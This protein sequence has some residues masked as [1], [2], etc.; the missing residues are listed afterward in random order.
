MLAATADA[1][2]AA[3]VLLQAGAALEA[4]NN[5][6]RCADDPDKCFAGMALHEDAWNVFVCFAECAGKGQQSAWNPAPV[7]PAE[8]AFLLM[9]SGVRRTCLAGRCLYCGCAA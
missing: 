9:P 7:V 2:A 6:S 4:R 1:A 5:A 3:A 8:P